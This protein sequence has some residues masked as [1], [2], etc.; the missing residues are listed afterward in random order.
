MYNNMFKTTKT[1]AQLVNN[2]FKTTISLMHILDALYMHIL[3]DV[4]MLYSCI[5]KIVSMQLSDVVFMHT[6]NVMWV[7]RIKPCRGPI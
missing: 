5:F 7:P 1:L 3:N 2:I 6:L 4:F